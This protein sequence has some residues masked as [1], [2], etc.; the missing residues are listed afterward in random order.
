VPAITARFANLGRVFKGGESDLLNQVACLAVLYEDLR[1]ELNGL[2]TGEER[3]G[4]LDTLGWNYRFFY[5]LRR[6]LVTLCEFRGALTRIGMSPE[7]KEAKDALALHHRQHIADAD[8][9]FQ[10][11]A[12]L[13]KGLRNDLGGHLKDRVVKFAAGHLD[14]AVGKAIWNSSPEGE[15]LALELHF[16]LDVVC[17]SLCSKFEEGKDAVEELH[18]ITEV[19]FAGFLHVQA[20]MYAIARAFLWDEFGR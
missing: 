9:F 15:V 18:R 13:L 4:D 8:R 10:E 12:D 6:S 3:L 5:F 14:N 7:F 19:V 17:Q 20:A 2:K 11:H 16:A 1:I